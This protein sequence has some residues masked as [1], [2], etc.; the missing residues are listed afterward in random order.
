MYTPDS[1]E[2]LQ[3]TGIDFQRHEEIGIGPNDF[4]ELMITSGLV[5]SHDT[6]WI[7]FHRYISC[8]FFVA[9]NNLSHSGY[10]FGYFVKLLTAQS[11][12][13]TEDAFFD[14]LKLW[15]PTVYDI[16]YLMKASK[17]LKG[18]L[19]EV[20]DDLGVCGEFGYIVNDLISV[21]RLCELGQVNKQGRIRFSLHQPFSKCAR[22]IS[23]IV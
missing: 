10:D 22:F 16:K 7:S 8:S 20:A 3:K 23:T 12:P 2:Q 5:L 21:P 9:V 18:G 14:L 17:V 1:I 4:A 15:F 19:Q 13:T 11:L 6:R